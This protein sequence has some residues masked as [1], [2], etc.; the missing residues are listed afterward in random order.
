MYRINLEFYPA[1]DGLERQARWSAK[2]ANE[3]FAQS[4]NDV[5]RIDEAVEDGVDLGP[6][7]R[8]QQRL[9]DAGNEADAGQQPLRRPSV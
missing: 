4:V 8:L 6:D 2:L 3:R 9:T 7:R 1:F 5:I